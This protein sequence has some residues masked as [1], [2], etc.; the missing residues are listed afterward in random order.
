MKH[1]AAPSE[2]PFDCV[3][4]PTAYSAPRPGAR[5]VGEFKG[6]T[7]YH[8]KDTGL[9]RTATEWKLLGRVVKLGEKPP[10]SR[11]LPDAGP[12]FAEWQTI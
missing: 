6:L 11:M 9:L 5:P 4:A 3:A 2:I 10:G 1:F 8:R 12:V 7:F